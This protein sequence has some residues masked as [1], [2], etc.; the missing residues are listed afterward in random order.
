MFGP[1]N[2]RGTTQFPTVA[3][4]SAERKINFVRANFNGDVCVASYR[5]KEMMY[6]SNGSQK[7]TK[8]PGLNKAHLDSENSMPKAVV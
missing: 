4:N 5:T 3:S 2:S 1:S 8:P 6:V 7:E